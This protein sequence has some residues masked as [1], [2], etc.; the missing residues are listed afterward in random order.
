[1]EVPQDR[2]FEAAREGIMKKLIAS[3]AK[4]GGRF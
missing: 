4:L 3:G 1:V 2:K